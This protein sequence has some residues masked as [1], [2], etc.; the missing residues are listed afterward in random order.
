MEVQASIN[1]TSVDIVQISPTTYVQGPEALCM[2]LDELK[3]ARIEDK[4]DNTWSDRNSI[5]RAY[6]N[7]CL[8][9]LREDISEKDSSGNPIFMKRA[10]NM[11]GMLPCFIVID[12]PYDYDTPS[13]CHF[14]W[15]AKR[16]RKKGLAAYMLNE[17]DV[18]S[19]DEILP[20]AEAFWSKYFARVQEEIN[21]EEESSQEED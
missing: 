3:Q 7:G 1:Y 11:S 4:D 5:I 17:L 19:A 9:G 2:L 16:A 15:T 21:Q 8:Y 12:K 20:E 13:V 14:L 10:Y 6:G 18:R